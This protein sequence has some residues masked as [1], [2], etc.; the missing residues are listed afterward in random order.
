MS[1]FVKLKCLLIKRL[2]L[3]LPCVDYEKTVPIVSVDDVL[4]KA[5]LAAQS[6]L[7]FGVSMQL[8][9]TKIIHPSGSCTERQWHK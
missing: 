2:M 8:N 5:N 9:T 7:F 1:L 3:I 4:A 6:P